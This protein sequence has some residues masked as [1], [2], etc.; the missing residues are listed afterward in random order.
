VV[1]V[2]QRDYGRIFVRP[3]QP[4]YYYLGLFGLA[5]PWT[6]WLAAGLVLP[7]ARKYRDNCRRVLIPW[8]WFVTLFA[9]FS[10][11]PGREQRYILPVVPA[12]AVL[13]AH[14]WHDLSAR[15][16][17]GESPPWADKMGTLHWG[18]LTLV[19]LGFGAAFVLP[20]PTV[21]REWLDHAAFLR[22]SWPAAVAV[23]ITL[24]GLAVQGWR[25]HRQGQLMRAAAATAAWTILGLTLQSYGSGRAP[26]ER[27]NAEAD[28]VGRLVGNAPIRYIVLTGKAADRPGIEFLFYM[29]RVVLPITAEELA[30]Y[31]S[32]SAQ[33]YVF[34]VDGDDYAEMLCESQFSPIAEFNDG[35]VAC[36]LWE[37][38]ARSEAVS[39]ADDEH[40][41]QIE[42]AVEKTRR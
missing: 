15:T 33:V 9:L 13:T 21:A 22:L 39:L 12:L 17:R 4:F 42:A 10:L 16:E 31:A 34:A 41:P 8:L 32:K 14:V 18:A 19:T 30:D 24:I 20:G 29:R 38:S 2:L 27:L 5:L 35:H 11:S 28:R 1:G 36:R 25:W 6:V 26:S 23:S 3:P 7:F 37:H 40:S